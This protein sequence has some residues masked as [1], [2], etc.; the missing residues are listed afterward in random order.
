[1][2]TSDL[3][4]NDTFDLDGTNYHLWRIHMF[5]RFWG[6]GPNALRIVLIGISIAKDGHSP[7]IEDMY[8]DCDT[9]LVIHQALTFEV[10]KAVTTCKSAHE[11]W[12]KLEDI[13]GGSN[14]DEFRGVNGGFLHI[15]KS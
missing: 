15:F 1:M 14:L 12:T 7:S 4:H 3:V 10:F 11:T 6:M 8:L 9:S 2:S 13:Y 5:C